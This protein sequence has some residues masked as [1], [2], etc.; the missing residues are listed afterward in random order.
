M[1]SE[2]VM[3]RLNFDGGTGSTHN[4]KVNLSLEMVEKAYKKGFLVM[5][6]G[7]IVPWSKINFII[8]VVRKTKEEGAKTI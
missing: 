2:M 5:D 3:Y 4:D 6:D 7:R 1:A 8:P